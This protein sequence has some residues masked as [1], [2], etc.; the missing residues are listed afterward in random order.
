[1]I[2]NLNG[3]YETIMYRS[4][5]GIRLYHNRENE[6]YPVHWHRALEIIMP[7]RNTYS[8]KITNQSITLEEGDILLIPPGEL[9]A[10]SYSPNG[11]RLIAQLDFSAINQLGGMDSLI[12][13]SHPFMLLR[14]NDNPDFMKELSYCLSEIEREYF[15]N[16]LFAETAIYSLYLRFFT[17]LGRS[18]VNA[19]VKFPDIAPSKQHEYLEKFMAVCN[20]IND[21]CTEDLTVDELA[22]RAGF[23]KSHFSRLFKQFT[24]M[25]CYAYLINKRIAYAERLLISPTLSIMDAAMQSG[26]NSLCTFNRIFKS[27][28][29]CTPSQY[30]QLNRQY[31]ASTKAQDLTN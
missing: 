8:I 17:L 4:L 20:F 15:A 23:S 2:E 16:D 22:I 11:E 24:G 21:H 6:D 7:Y 9:H 3:I 10:L 31:C 29:D 28:K 12:H 30:R 5:N 18:T 14:K 27:V 1:M 25:T 13:L 19:A 26:F